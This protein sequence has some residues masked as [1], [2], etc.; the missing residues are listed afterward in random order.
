[1]LRP[2]ARSAIPRQRRQ[3]TGATAVGRST[4][5]DTTSAASSSGPPMLPPC[6]ERPAHIEL[7]RSSL[8]ERGRAAST[9]D[10][11]LCT[12]CGFH[13]F[14]RIDGRVP[15]NAVQYI[16]RSQIHPS[17]SRIRSLRCD[18]VF[19]R[20]ST[21]NCSAGPPERF[22]RS[23]RWTTGA[24]VAPFGAPRR[25]PE[26]RRYG[27]VSCVGGRSVYRRSYVLSRCFRRCW[28]TSDGP[29]GEGGLL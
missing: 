23:W 15:S 14:A 19:D 17:E 29:L 11:R 2:S 24:P 27:A 5:S 20:P 18:Q 1:M 6:W 3:L 21:L 22:T 12:G 28:Q 25:Q 9:I 8:D 7:Y 13:R 16:R 10:R 4:P 26:R